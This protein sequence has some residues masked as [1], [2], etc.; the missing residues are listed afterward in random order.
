MSFHKSYNEYLDADYDRDFN[1]LYI[2]VN[3]TIRTG[4]VKS[5]KEVDG[6]KVSNL[7]IYNIETGDLTYFF[8]KGSKQNIRHYFFEVF[9]DEEKERMRLNK[10]SRM[11]FNNKK[12]PKRPASD[13][14]FL[15]NEKENK[16]EVELW[17]SSKK[18]ENKKLV[19]TFSK[20]MDWR[21]DVFNQKILFLYQLENE[22]RVE[23]ID[24]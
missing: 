1:L 23:A 17:Q 3:P 5:K 6:N 24:W 18:G 22:V 9:Y 19:K 13:I 10:E 2:E 20:K 7:A 21:I 16:E 14:L 8:E 15:V 12:I 11:I 4:I